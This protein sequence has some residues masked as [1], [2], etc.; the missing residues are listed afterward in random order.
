MREEAV[1]LIGKAMIIKGHIV[2][3]QDLYIDGEVQGTLEAIGFRL[4][5]GPNGKADAG[6]KAQEIE[7]MGTITGDVESATRVSIRRGGSLIGDVKTAGISID[8]GGY[9]KGS[10][11]I[12]N[13]RGAQANG[14]D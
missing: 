1:T 4:T 3:K 5:I 9:F 14:N 12:V 6:A 2:S 8:D 7:I 11:D 10:I 13:G